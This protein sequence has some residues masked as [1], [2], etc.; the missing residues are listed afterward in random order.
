MMQLRALPATNGPSRPAMIPSAGRGAVQD[1][2]NLPRRSTKSR[3]HRRAIRGI[4]FL[5]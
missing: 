2:R 4:F 3:Y 5:G 1:Q